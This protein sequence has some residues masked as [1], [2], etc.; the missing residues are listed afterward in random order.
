MSV[1][2][3]LLLTGS[4]ILLISC[5]APLPQLVSGT[6]PTEKPRFDKF[7]KGPGLP[8]EK[9]SLLVGAKAGD[10]ASIYIIEVDGIKMEGRR[11]LIGGSKAAMLL[12]GKHNVVIQLYD[13]GRIT[14]PLTLS[15]VELEANVGYLINFTLNYPENFQ[16]LSGNNQLKISIMIN[17]LDNKATVY[18]KTF[19]GWGKETR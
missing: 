5:A 19:N 13:K 8:R 15:D 14:M 2:E 12:P 1:Y 3:R 16:Y 4:F 18:H 17:N 11:S 9:T 6:F 10:Q 7:Y